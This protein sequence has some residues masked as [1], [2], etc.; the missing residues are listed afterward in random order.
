M[1]KPAASK[2]TFT[3]YGLLGLV[4]GTTLLGLAACAEKHEPP[5][6]GKR[7]AVL[8]FEAPLRAD[9]ALAGVDVMLPDPEA[10]T[11]WPQADDNAAHLPGHI[12]LK[13]RVV[14]TWRRSVSSSFG[15]D[16]R[17]INTPVVAD[18][19]LFLTTPDGEIVALQAS[20]GKRLWKR[21]IASD[22]PDL[23]VSGGL[24]YD[25]GVLYATTADGSV[26]AMTPDKGKVIWR[27]DVGA[28]VRAAPTV[29]DGN[30]F[31]VS[32]DNRLH[33]LS[34][35]DGRLE[36]THSGIEELVSMLGGAPV[37][38]SGGVVVVAYSSGELFALDEQTGRMLWTDSISVRTSADPMSAMTDIMAPPVIVGDVVYAASV[39]GQLVTYDLRNGNR[40]W[41][42]G[43]GTAS[44]PLIAGN[45][46]FVVT[47]HDQL[48][49]I[50]RENGNLRWV[51][52]LGNKS[53]RKGDAKKSVFWMGPILVGDRLIVVS[54]DGLAA[55]I[56]PYT[57]K[58]LSL[59]SISDSG[60]S[61]MPVVADNTLYFFTNNGE[62][63]AYR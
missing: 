36:W 38:V 6:P 11:S 10:T 23:A 41:Q 52:N 18:G 49:A 17:L 40:L 33:V 9:P 35:K 62:I 54:N 37:A 57:G 26:L 8:Q 15:G 14:E 20:D 48:V 4:C 39:S 60:L 7:E 16:T 3:R 30:V 2:A 25:H 61:V 56:S 24:A 19:K 21:D 13:D 44:L 31:V 12:A 51:T 32:H 58:Q 42:V 45:H 50:N 22:D 43:A 29:A 53:L 63:V 28:P 5:L 34:A 1:K 47:S 59:V 46:A 27:Q 55:A